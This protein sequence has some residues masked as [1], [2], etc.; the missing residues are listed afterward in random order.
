MSNPIQAI[1]NV[2]DVSKASRDNNSPLSDE[3]ILT[4]LKNTVN[5]EKLIQKYDRF[6]NGYAAEDL[7]M[8]I[9]SMLPWV[10]LITPLGQE[11]FPEKSKENLQVCDYDVTY[12]VGD[13]EH[14]ATV[15]IEVK[16]VDGE[17][18]THEI[19]KYQYEVLK[20]YANE[21]NQDLLFALFWR[22][23]MIWTVVPIEAFDEKSSVYKISFEKAFL[24]DVSAIFGDYMYVFNED[25]YRK[26]VFSK[27]DSVESEYIHEHFKYGR[28]VYEGLSKDGK[29]YSKIDFL[30]TPMLDALFD[31]RAV[32]VVEGD[33]NTELI[34]KIDKLPYHYRLSYVILRYLLKIYCY[35]KSD[36]YLHENSVVENVFNIVDTIRRECCGKKYYLVPRRNAISEK[37]FKAQFGK[38]DWIVNTLYIR[39]QDGQYVLASHDMP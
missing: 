34:E 6:R 25:Y 30:M 8:R 11:Q 17:K 2:Y 33:Y 39:C 26:S 23:S 5:D 38:S 7:F 15:L 3:T 20:N 28:T 37:L 21:K 9:Y 14:K 18:Q 36:M 29:D 13:K 27:D 31:F 16:L 35:E 19:K 12:E 22:K 1:R 4:L 24:N 32:S 10:R